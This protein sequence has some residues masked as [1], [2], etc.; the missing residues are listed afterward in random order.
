MMYDLD[1]GNAKELLADCMTF[2]PQKIKKIPLRCR[3]I[4]VGFVSGMT[5][6]ELNDKLKE[7]GCEQLY[8]RN[9][10]EAGLIF[11]F[12]NHMTYECWRRLE[13]KYSESVEHDAEKQKFFSGSTVTYR[14]L[15]QYVRQNST[16][17]GDIFVTQRITE[18]MELQLEEA[19]GE[20]GKFRDFLIQNQRNF[21]TVR[22]KSRY[23]F[24]K[25]LY[26]YTEKKISNYMEAK[27]SGFGMEQA[28][29]ELYILKSASRLRQRKMTDEE[30]REMLLDSSISFGGIYDAFNYYYFEYVSSDWMEVLMDY[31][32][33]PDN[34]LE[35]Q[36]K[37]LAKALRDYEPKWSSMSDE[38][39]I[40]E[41]YRE[42]EE[43]ERNMD[44]AYSLEG[45]GRGYQKNRSGEKA[46]RN[47]IKGVWDIDRTI[48]ICYLLF[49]GS[50]LTEQDVQKI[51]KKRMNEILRECGFAGLK[52]NN[53][54]D[55]FV[56]EYLKVEDPV[57]YLMEAVTQYALQEKNFFLY[58]MYR[59]SVNNDEL[60]RKLI[61]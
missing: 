56:M 6:E 13:E 4:A 1:E 48:L 38:E 41:K 22:E 32:G 49:F 3:L 26:Y 40:K 50:V 23:Y 8:A 45:K 24:C 43:R 21:R 11:A 61:D 17:Y 9:R 53:D 39:V 35:S 14:E 2:D 59:N 34:M 18:A 19:Q 57:D 51:D 60:I 52:D 42:T 44:A 10:L 27:N 58:H 20:E 29:S 31:Y 12:H 5:L 28:A 37:E 16:E 36:K 33:N 25:Y 54:F 15:E 55:Y 46:V 47:Y 7:E 30:L